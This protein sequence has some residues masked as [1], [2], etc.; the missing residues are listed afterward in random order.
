M[1]KK[2]KNRKPGFKPVIG[3]TGPESTGKTKLT[4]DLAGIFNGIVVPEYARAYVERLNRPYN[5]QDI[6]NIADFQIKERKKY[7]P[8]RK[9]WIFFDT[10][11]IITLVW[12]DKVFRTYPSYIE[13]NLLKNKVDFYL[14][15]NTDLEWEPDPVRENGGKKREQLYLEYKNRLE[16]YNFNYAEVKGSGEERLTSA[17]TGLKKFFGNSYVENEIVKDVF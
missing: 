6:I 7:F 13:T 10:D 8:E 4:L 2:L 14:L 15:C 9:N 5:Y 11:L 1:E 17:I 12:L 3:I 16:Y